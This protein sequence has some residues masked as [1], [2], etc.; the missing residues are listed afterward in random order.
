VVA[1]AGNENGQA[2]KI[3][4]RVATFKAYR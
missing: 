1:G 4:H 3:R 2:G